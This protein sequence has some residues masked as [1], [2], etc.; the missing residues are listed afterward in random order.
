MAVPASVL[1]VN[2]KIARITSVATSLSMSELPEGASKWPW[3]TGSSQMGQ[4]TAFIEVQRRRYGNPMPP[5][6]DLN[7]ALID[8]NT[9][10]IVCNETLERLCEYFE[11]ITE[12]DPDLAESDVVYGDGVLTVKL[13]GSKGT[14]VI[15][16][17]ETR[18]RFQCFRFTHSWIN[19]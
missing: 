15:N 11:E 13:G 17:Y 8:A 7:E 3:R 1:R 5:S 4:P 10:E 2:F 12:T 18:T 9:Y 16:R 6:V 14:Y 19:F